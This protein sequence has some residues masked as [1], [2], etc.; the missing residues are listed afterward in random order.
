[1]PAP[2]RLIAQR[3]AAQVLFACSAS[4][5]LPGCWLDGSS[6][7]AAAPVPAPLPAPTT[8][9]VGG[10]ISGLTAAGLVL[11][12][13][14]DALTVAANATGFTLPTAVAQGGS[15]AVTV[16]TQ[17]AGL[18]CSLTQSTGIIN[19]ANVTNVAVTC[20]AITHTLGGAISGLASSGLV[21]LNGSDM[22]SLSSGALTFT[23]ALPV[24]EGGAY[25]VSVKTQPS[26]ETCSVGNGTGT[27]GT[28][29]VAAV[30]L[31]CSANA[32]K[33]GGTIA[34]LTTA[35]LILANGTDTV[36][37]AANAT[38]FTFAKTVAFGGM[39]SVTVQ[40]QPAGQ[41]CTV[42]GSFPATMGAGDVGNVAVTCAASTALLTPVV[43]QLACP[44]Q[45]PYVDGVGA[46]ASV[47]SS[48]M[49]RDRAGNLFVLSFAA[50]TVRMVSPAGVVST[51]A[52]TVG[53][54]GNV[55]G[56]GAAAQF[57]TPTGVAADSTGNAFI[58]ES[59]DVRKVT[60]AGVVSTAAGQGFFAG[61]IDGPA[62]SAKFFAPSAI[63][64]DSN[65]N[66]YIADTQNGRIRKLTPAGVVST[67]AGGGSANG[68]QAGFADGTGTAALFYYPAGVATDSAGN[69]FVADNQNH[70]IRK[71]T[72][73]GVVTTVAGQ[74]GVRGIAD[75]A[76]AAALF[77]YP[78][79]LA[80]D[81]A[82]NLY[83]IDQSFQAV[84]VI[85][86]AGVVT[87]L[88]WSGDSFTNGNGVLF[89]RPATAAA[90][91]TSVTAIVANPGGGVLVGLG[92]S[93]QKLG[94]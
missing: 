90:L 16:K 91:T 7:P 77:T 32:Y 54:T 67:L 25:A 31:T 35:G 5:A 73:A 38:S 27:M 11:A 68:K 71:I 1:M 84:R 92:C 10:S 29:N 89:T 34:G 18:Q 64:F 55:D 51:I 40:Q 4:L 87:T 85:T 37:P 83:V 3:R 72:P 81:A 50:N 59:H 19:S 58:T 52:G 28:A 12:N 74:P 43:G 20:A 62:A 42:A 22:L 36:S 49:A 69:V 94:C 14:N 15:Y 41:T 53:I 48:A 56:T 30:Q 76:G 17:P 65:G 6:A 88:A 45:N 80:V 26:G 9:T 75:G 66:A 21:L 70:L 13:G 60:P 39:F 86:P 61:L 23:F 79:N 46:D 93:I 82:D 2:H 8:Y 33:L 78:T 44:A 57:R 47:A 24:A 63:A